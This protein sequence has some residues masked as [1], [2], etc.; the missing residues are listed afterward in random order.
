MLKVKIAKNLRGPRVTSPHVRILT[1][2]GDRALV[3]YWSYDPFK[4]HGVKPALTRSETVPPQL[5]INPAARINQYVSGRDTPDSLSGIGSATDSVKRRE[6]VRYY[7]K[8]V[9][10]HRDVQRGGEY[11]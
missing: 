1:E 9:I 3:Y 10:G 8:K 6:K 5:G 2:N 7:W 11:G 4:I